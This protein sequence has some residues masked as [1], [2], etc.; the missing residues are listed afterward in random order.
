VPGIVGAPVVAYTSTTHWIAAPAAGEGDL[1]WLEVGKS[2]G[3]VRTV[4]AFRGD[5]LLLRVGTANRTIVDSGCTEAPCDGV[6]APVGGSGGV[7]GYAIAFPGTG[8]YV[9]TVGSTG[10]ATLVA[11]DASDPATITA[12]HLVALT[13]TAMVWVDDGAIRTAPLAGGAATVL[14][15]ADATGGEVTSLAA[16]D[17]VVAWSAKLPL[18][19]SAVSARAGGGAV[20]ELGREPNPNVGL[21]GGVGVAA[22]GTVVAVHRSYPAGQQQVDIIAFAA[23]GIRRTLLS[24]LPF[25]RKAPFEA[26][27]PSVSG[28]LLA[29]RR[30]EGTSGAQDAIYVINLFTGTTVRAAVS[31]RSTAR[32]SD[33]SLAGGRLVWAKTTF[34]RSVFQRAQI[35]SAP[36]R[37]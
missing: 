27:R 37:G 24:S 33:P 26:M 35:F 4:A 11:E 17:G 12:P 28:S 20:V 25:S 32:L 2:A 16:I 15:A 31:L 21:L 6:R 19:G 36:V 30:R 34:R 23:S 8:G 13:P 9:G 29:V 5:R 14:V 10:V 22:D 3:D 1:A 7:F 18:G